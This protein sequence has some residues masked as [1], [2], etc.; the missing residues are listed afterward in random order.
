MIDKFMQMDST[1]WTRHIYIMVNHGGGFCSPWLLVSCDFLPSTKCPSII[2]K[3]YMEE[4]FEEQLQ[5]CQ[6]DYLISIGSCHYQKPTTSVKN[7]IL[8]IRKQE[9]GKFRE[10]GVSVHDTPEFLEMLLTEHPEISFVVLQLNYIDWEN[11]GI[12]S[13]EIYEVAVKHNKPIV[14]MEACKGGTLAEIPDEAVKLMKDY[15]PDASVASWA[16]RF[17][18]S[19]PGVRVVLAG[20]PKMEFLDD[21]METFNNFKPLNEEEYKILDQVVEIINSNTPI[22]CTYCRYCSECRCDAIPIILPYN[23][24]VRLQGQYN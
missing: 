8:R 20:M 24:Y 23:D 18:G 3:I 22:A 13:R 19:L 4:I 7:G 16:Y 10:F 21:N 15:N 14:V 1:F 17:V 5:K 11:P 6:V 9:E 2:P 12:R